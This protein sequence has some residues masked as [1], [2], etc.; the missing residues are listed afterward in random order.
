ME[1][2]WSPYIHPPKIAV[3][4]SNG[5]YMVLPLQFL[6]ASGPIS[7]KKSQSGSA[8]H[9]CTAGIELS[10]HVDVDVVSINLP[11]DCKC[12]GNVA[13]FQTEV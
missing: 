10:S 6:K 5:A 11:G 3:T 12:P 7:G 4:R 1:Q 2:S 9:I 8:G 13:D